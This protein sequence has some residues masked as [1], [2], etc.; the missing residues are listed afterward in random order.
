M[1]SQV[2]APGPQK[3][4]LPCQQ[5]ALQLLEENSAACEITAMVTEGGLLVQGGNKLLFPASPS[6]G[7]NNKPDS[8]T[9]AQGK[10]G[11]FCFVG[12]LDFFF[13]LS[14]KYQDSKEAWGTAAAYGS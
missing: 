2:H 11:F 9:A 14:S 6:V 12:F 10:G 5:K 3:R 1:R 8:T 13:P 4:S 7:R